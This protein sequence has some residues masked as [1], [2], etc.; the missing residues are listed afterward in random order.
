MDGSRIL[1]A[2]HRGDRKRFPENT[3]PAFES[4]LRFGVDMIETNVHMTSDGAVVRP[5]R[6]DNILCLWYNVQKMFFCS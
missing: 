6:L 5:Q 2:A 1:L 3:M 4:A